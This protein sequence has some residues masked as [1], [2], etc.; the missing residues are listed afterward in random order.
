MTNKF[1]GSSVSSGYYVFIK[2]DDHHKKLPIIQNS[3]IIISHMNPIINP[4]Y[5]YCNITTNRKKI[6]TFLIPNTTPLINVY[7]KISDSLMYKNKFL[8]NKDIEEMEKNGFK[9]KIFSD[10][11][12][13]KQSGLVNSSSLIF[14][15]KYKFDNFSKPIES[16]LL[17]MVSNY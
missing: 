7:S 9:I 11:L 12:F 10:W 5:I 14:N 4:Y 15:K 8:T 3:S 16:H 2:D 6:V 1:H 13:L 17:N